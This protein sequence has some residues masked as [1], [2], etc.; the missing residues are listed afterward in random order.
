MKRR[1]PIKLSNRMLAIGASIAMVST[2]AA[3]AEDTQRNSGFVE[4][5]KNF[6]EKIS[7]T[8]RDS[9]RAL[10]QDKDAK[11]I[12]ES[13]LSMASLDLREQQD[14]YTLRLNLP[15]RDMNKVEINL[16]GD[17]LHIVAP[18]EGTAGRY[19]QDIQLSGVAANAA[20]QIERKAE[21][22]LIIVTVPKSRDLA[23]TTPTPTPSTDL[24]DTW[25]RD[26]LARMDR[27][28][29][30]MDRI[31]NEAFSEF[32]SQPEF[33]E[34]FDQARFGSSFD[35]QEE[36]DRYVVRAYLPERDMNNVNA[37]VEGQL[38]KLDAKAEN[39]RNEE[40]DGVFLSS[41]SEYSQ[42][43]TLPGPVQADKMTVERKEN[44]LVVTLPKASA[45]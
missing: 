23:A 12:S 15:N 11:K 14:S 4:N 38:L 24:W 7:E 29:R 25:D 3:A 10:W 39:T 13:T 30:E 31:F 43:L 33:R 2:A 32:R 21:D 8:F 44:M 36:K 17:T 42:V 40:K 22:N 5:I 9:W 28:R 18:A 20:P 34:F 35:L 19:E 1:G 41:K 45:S 16:S 26:V 27:M 37:T 6:Q